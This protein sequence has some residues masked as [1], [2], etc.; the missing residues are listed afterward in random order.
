MIDLKR[1]ER[2]VI[3]DYYQDGLVDMLLGAYLLLIGLALPAGTVAPFII[4]P[5]WG[6]VPLLRFLKKHL[7]YPRTGY[8]TLRVANPGPGSSSVPWRWAWWSWSSC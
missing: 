6:L 7:V 1:I 2:A 8:A 4:L 3:R 5:I